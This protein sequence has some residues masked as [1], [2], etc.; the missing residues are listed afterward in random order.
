[1]ASLELEIGEA[2]IQNAIAV[3]IVE[4]FSGEQRDKVIR[5]VVRAHMSVKKDCY[6]KQTLLDA[7]V[8]EQIRTM[9]TKCLME[10]IEKAR[11]M[12]EQVVR[13]V[14]GPGFEESICDQLRVGLAQRR[15][16]GIS[17]SVDVE[18]DD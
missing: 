8:G 9:A 11:P 18:E 14:L 12:V 16:R 6:S 10:E 4:S 13:E 7:T 2:Q 5:D 1:M 3:A 15:V 17:V